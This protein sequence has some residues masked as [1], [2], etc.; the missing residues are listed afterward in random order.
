MQTEEFKN[1]IDQSLH[2]Y[3]MDNGVNNGYPIHSLAGYKL[4]EAKEI[5]DC[6]AKL[7]ADLHEGNDHFAEAK[8]IYYD[9]DNGA[10]NEMH[11]VEIE[12]EDHV[13]ID[14]DSLMPSTEYG[15]MISLKFDD[16]IT[17]VCSPQYFVT[18]E[19][20]AVASPTAPEVSIYPNPAT[21]IVHIDGVETAEV[22]V[23]NVAGQLLKTVNGS[24]EIVVSDLPSGIYL[25]RITSAMPE[26][27][28]V[29]P[30]FKH[31]H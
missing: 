2:A 3:V 25:L 21:D 20:D 23:Y 4:W 9:L 24:N 26:T 7:S 5:T 1:Q 28:Y 18:E 14:I 6:S 12:V 15:F 8:F 22:R 13:E 27:E 10:V 29:L 19:Y 11:F 30:L 17:W 16:G 31:S